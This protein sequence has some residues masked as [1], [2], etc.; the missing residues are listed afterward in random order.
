MQ[1]T[2]HESKQRERVQAGYRDR[3]TKR[4]ERIRLDNAERQR[5]CR[6]RKREAMIY[7]TVPT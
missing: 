6:E 1:R 2:R 4:L 3:E 5:K 7:E